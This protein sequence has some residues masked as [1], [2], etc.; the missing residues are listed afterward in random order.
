MTEAL[1]KDVPPFY[2]VLLIVN[3]FFF[4]F[5][6]PISFYLLR[7]Q[8]WI[9]PFCGNSATDSISS[10]VLILS[11]SFV[12][13]LPGL[14]FRDYITGNNGP[15]PVSKRVLK[16][17]KAKNWCFWKVWRKKEKS[18]KADSNITYYLWLK[19]SDLGKAASFLNVK[20]AIV[21][22]FLIGSGLA[23]MVNILTMPALFFFVSD[24]LFLFFIF[25]LSI[26]FTEIAFIYE[27]FFFRKG[28]EDISS[29]IDNR[30]KKAQLKEVLLNL[31]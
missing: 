2:I 21:N 1:T 24:R 27:R 20:F 10:V 6:S 16:A 23:L 11:I 13:G 19:R 28:Y 29:E 5:L 15:I 25:L 8:A 31:E 18:T 14:L 17:F 7:T 3:G 12:A 26:F 4:C 9:N 30:Y 22:G